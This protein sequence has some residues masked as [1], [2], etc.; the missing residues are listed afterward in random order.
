MLV[1]SRR[2]QEAI[3]IA[4]GSITVIVLGVR[5]SIVKLGIEAPDE[6]C[7]LRAELCDSTNRLDVDRTC[8]TAT[9]QG[10]RS[11]AAVPVNKSADSGCTDCKVDAQQTARLTPGVSYSLGSRLATVLAK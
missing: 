10:K 1:L 7:I 6:V 11:T 3:V 5:G 8:D 9:P 2:A 4:D